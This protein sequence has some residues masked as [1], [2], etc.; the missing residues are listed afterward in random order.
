[1]TDV[2]ITTL[3]N[4]IDALE[5]REYIDPVFP[6][7]NTDLDDLMSRMLSAY[8]DI[9]DASRLDEIREDHVELPDGIRETVGENLS[10]F[11][12]E[13]WV[14]EN[15]GTWADIQEKVEWAAYDQFYGSAQQIIRD[16]VENEYDDDPMGYPNNLGKVIP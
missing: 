4:S 12:P 7:E 11:E 5:I 3:R 15:A 1:M 13:S 10:D 9:E 2:S 8:L 14:L 16:A 6:I